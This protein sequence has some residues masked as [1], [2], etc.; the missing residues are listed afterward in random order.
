MIKLKLL[1]EAPEELSPQQPAAPQAQPQAQPAPAAQAAKL[2]DVG[3][4]YSGFEQAMEKSRAEFEALVSSKI[5]GKKI[6]FKGS[7]GYGQMPKDWELTAVDVSVANP[8][9]KGYEIVVK[10]GKKEYYVDKRNKIQIVSDSSPAQ[11]ATP[12][13]TPPP[14]AN[15]PPEPPALENPKGPPADPDKKPQIKQ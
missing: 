10:D 1:F 12:E 2:Y 15:K 3:L 5:K 7:K 13:Q 11:P 9:N 6:K 4:D 8:Y 14:S